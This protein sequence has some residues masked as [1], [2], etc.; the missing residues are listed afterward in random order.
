MSGLTRI[1]VHSW[2]SAFSLTASQHAML[3]FAICMAV[4]LFPRAL[5]LIDAA[6]DRAR[7]QAYGGIARMTFGTLGETLFSTLHA[8]LQMLWHTRFVITILLGQGSSWGAQDRVAQGTT[9]GNALRNQWWQTACGLGWGWLVWRLSPNAFWWFMPMFCGMALAVPLS[10]LTSRASWGAAAKRLGLFLT[11]E[12]T[13]PPPELI[14]LREGA[15]APN[16]PTKLE[17]SVLD[18]YINAIHVSLLRENKLNPDTRQ[19]LAKLGV[20]GPRARSLAEHVLADGFAA[21]P[22]EDQKL[23]LNDADTM[24]W[25]HR[26]LWLRPEST[27]APSWRAAM[28][29][30]AN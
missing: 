5:A 2:M 17:E 6:L 23:V 27:V 3:V 12:E 21:L 16:T 14:A 8:P 29:T 20:G 13:A 26:Q 24:S 30:Y 10:V 7:R 9:W 25:L 11:P 18:P 4:L 1:A 19:A 28:K 22:P 15:S